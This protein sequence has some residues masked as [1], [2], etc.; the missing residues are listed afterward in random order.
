MIRVEVAPDATVA[1]HTHPGTIALCLE[2]GSV[3][4]GVVK[5]TAA[6]T[7]ADTAATPEAAEQLSVSETL[8]EPGDCLTFD[9][10]QTAHTL[11][12]PGGPAVIWQ[13]QL[14]EVG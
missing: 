9:A 2:S 8:L 13:V 4:F 6:V 5:G 10:S 12:G 1:M 7:R 14:Y 3:V 11:H